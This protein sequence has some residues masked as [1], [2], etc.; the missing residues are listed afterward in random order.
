MFQLILMFKLVIAYIV[1]KETFSQKGFYS[2]FTKR[3]IILYT[4]GTKPNGVI[5]LTDVFDFF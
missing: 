5:I 1:S 4:D 2:Q 3:K